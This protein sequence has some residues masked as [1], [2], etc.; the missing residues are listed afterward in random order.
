MNYQNAACAPNDLLPRKQ[1][2][3]RA[4]FFAVTHPRVF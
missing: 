3:N 1:N 2:M 4:L